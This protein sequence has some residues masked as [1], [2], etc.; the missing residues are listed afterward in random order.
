MGAGG[1][2][3]DYVTGVVGGWLWGEYAGKHMI[4]IRMA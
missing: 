4:I 3:D 1:H 2:I